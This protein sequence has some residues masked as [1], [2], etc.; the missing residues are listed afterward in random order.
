MNPVLLTA[1]IMSLSF[2]LFYP[3]LSEYIYN[4]SNNASMI[5][6]IISM[7]SAVCILALILGGYLGDKFG[8]RR[9]TGIGTILLG[10]A[11]LMYASAFGNQELFA[12][13]IC[14]GL[15]VIYFPSF[16]AIIMDTTAQDHLTR[17]FT[18]SFIVEHILYALTPVLGGFMKDSYG[19]LGLRGGFVTC[20]VTTVII[21]LVR[22]RLLSE[23]ISGSGGIYLKILWEAY[24]SLPRDFLGI[25]GRVRRLVFLRS[26]CLITAISIFYYF[27]VL[28]A[29]RYTQALSFNS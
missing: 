23:T 20:G 9:V 22:I 28:Y 14:E 3:Y 8:R 6:A 7:R 27:A 18:L 25:K 21:G 10:I 5:G 1:S 24:R 26:L 13:A 16:N 11:Q 29:T 17:V 12:A 15:S 19:I 2:G 4:I